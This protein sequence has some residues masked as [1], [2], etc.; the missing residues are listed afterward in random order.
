M[1]STFDPRAATWRT[2]LSLP[3]RVGIVEAVSR[4]PETTV[5]RVAAEVQIVGP[6]RAGNPV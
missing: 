1:K 3:G 5:R 2:L 4:D 6:G